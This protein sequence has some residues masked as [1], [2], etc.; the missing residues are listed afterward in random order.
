M[1]MEKGKEAIII[2]A[3]FFIALFHPLDPNHG[4]A[5][6]FIQ[7]HKESS[8]LYTTNNYLISEAVTMLLLRSKNLELAVT[9]AHLCYSQQVAWFS[10]NQV[11]QVLQSE[12]LEVFKAQ[13]K[14][15]GEFFS[16]ADC[17]LIAQA[18]RQ[19]IKTILTF[20]QSFKALEK[21]DMRI[22]P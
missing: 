5:K 3:S 21:S 8:T 18:G 2:D 12:A 14:Y 22:L 1:E 4:R 17:T 6:G 10:I 20:D 9:F 7:E 15:K 13:K 11:D 19:K 16:F